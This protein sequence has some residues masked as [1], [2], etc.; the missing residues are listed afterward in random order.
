MSVVEE[1][2]Q[3]MQAAIA[4]DAPITL[5]TAF[6][7]D[8]TEPSVALLVDGYPVFHFRR[9]ELLDAIY[10]LGSDVIDELERAGLP[11]TVQP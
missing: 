11:T 2:A 6:A 4:S 9:D 5:A 7:P 3:D 8:G 1:F 10:V